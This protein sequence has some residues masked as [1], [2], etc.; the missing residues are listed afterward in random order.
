MTEIEVNDIFDSIALS[1]N[2]FVESGFEKGYLEGTRSKAADGRDLGFQKG[3]QL[4]TEVGFYKGFAEEWS[5]HLKE[6]GKEDKKSVK[7]LAACEKVI[8]LTKEFPEENNKDKD[9]REIIN[10][11]RAKFKVACSLQKINPE[12][13][14]ETTS[15]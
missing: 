1:E 12:F 11:I 15:W 3:I 5:K 8:S 9:L 13:N 4:G 7:A 10:S 6:S 2:N 14:F